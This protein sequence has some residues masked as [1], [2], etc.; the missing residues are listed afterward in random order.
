MVRDDLFSQ[1]RRDYYDS[2]EDGSQVIIRQFS[3]SYLKA[4]KYRGYWFYFYRTRGVF[5][6]RVEE[7]QFL[8]HDLLQEITAL[9]GSELKSFPYARK[10]FYSILDDYIE[11]FL[12][13]DIDSDLFYLLE[14]VDIELSNVD[15][16][17]DDADALS[18]HE[19]LNTLVTKASQMEVVELL[20]LMELIDAVRDKNRTDCKM[21]V[22]Y[23]WV[24]KVECFYKN[25]QLSI[26][27]RVKAEREL[28]NKYRNV[29]RSL[30]IFLGRNKYKHLLVAGF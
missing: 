15:Y 19:G 7:R 10:N 24:C 20:A 26:D 25:P 9:H 22:L 16:K 5:I 21:G 3:N 27:P 13:F 14:Q 11:I 18:T 29:E 28:L 17:F 8:D 6:H 12:E 4:F 1:V 2:L 30:R 23:R